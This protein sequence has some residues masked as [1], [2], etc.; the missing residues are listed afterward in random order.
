[1]SKYF[2]M[3]NINPNVDI[4]KLEK[5]WNFANDCRKFE[6]TNF[7]MRGAY[8]WAYIT[9]GIAAYGWFLTRS[10]CKDIRITLCAFA[11][12]NVFNRLVLFILALL[13]FFFSLSWVLINK[14]SK[15]WQR[16]WEAHVF[17]LE[18]WIPGD[19]YKIFLD[20]DAESN[21]FSRCIFSKDAYN[22]SVT[23]IT[24]KCAQLVMILA[25][26]LAFFHLILLFLPEWIV[27]LTELKFFNC[28]YCRIGLAVI[29][30]LG[31][32]ALISELFINKCKGNE[33]GYSN[34]S[35]AEPYVWKKAKRV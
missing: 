14:G 24:I 11:N 33:D 3:L 15:F 25:G 34:H 26:L 22:Y 18:K 1:M 6:I 27:C 21:K 23:K 28:F 9:A 19:I 29:S 31:L 32:I 7:W 4:N 2:E 12:L 10:F 17:S 8:Y 30:F 5:A 35:A 16:C 13:V 20:T